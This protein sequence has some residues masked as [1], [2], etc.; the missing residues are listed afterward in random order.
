MDE[1]LNLLKGF[2]P[3]IATAVAGPLGGAAVSMIAKKFGVEDSVAAVAQAIAGDPKAEEKLREL[4][5][6]YARL[7]L[8]NVKGARDM[9]VA[10][11]AQSDVFSKRFVYYFAAYWSV[12]AVIYIA[13]ITFAPIPQANLRFA[14]TILGFLLGTVVATILNFFFGTSKSS[15]DKTDK[16]AEMMRGAS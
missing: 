5:M 15:Q 8:E 11:L 9:Q 4:D 10:A 16:M 14:D 13:C 7:H 1:L 6:E 2:A 3:A 12:C